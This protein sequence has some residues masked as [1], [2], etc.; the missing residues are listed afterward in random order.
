MVRIMIS[1]R[2]M[3]IEDL[4]VA[5]MLLSQLGYPLD[6]G[7]VR[8]RYEAVTEA[9]DHVAMVAEQ[10]GSPRLTSRKRTMSSTVDFTPQDSASRTP[11]FTRIGLSPLNA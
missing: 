6:T 2:P 9:E 8:R 7:E 10:A 4:P 5:Q 11:G 1:I 3:T